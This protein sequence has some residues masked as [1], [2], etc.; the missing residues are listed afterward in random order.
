M[1]AIIRLNAPSMIRLRT[2]PGSGIAGSAAVSRLTLRDHASGR[3]A[4]PF[5][6]H[7][8]DGHE[9]AQVSAVAQPGERGDGEPCPDQDLA[10]DKQEIHDPDIS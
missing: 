7:H 10:R 4:Q 1:T 3:K 6:H 5:R 8:P 2:S 9:R